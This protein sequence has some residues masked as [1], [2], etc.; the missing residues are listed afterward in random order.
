[1]PGYCDELDLAAQ[2]WLKSFKGMETRKRDVEHAEDEFGHSISRIERTSPLEKNDRFPKYWDSLKSPNLQLN[3]ATEKISPRRRSIELHLAAIVAVILQASLLVIA[4]VVPYRAH[5]YETQPWGLPCYIGG[6]VLLFIGMLACSVAIERST[7][8]FKW[9]PSSGISNKTQYSSEVRHQSMD[10]FWVQRKQ[11]VS[12]QDFDS[13]VIS[14]RNKQ[15]ISTSSRREDVLSGKNN[16]ENEDCRRIKIDQI[17]DN[18]SKNV[19]QANKPARS[20]EDRG[21]ESDFLAVTAIFAGGAGFTIQ[22]IGL[23][24]LPWPC[25]V[26]QLCATIAMAIIR[27]LVRRRLGD[28]PSYC[29]A[30]SRYELDLLATQLV[31]S[32]RTRPPNQPL[33]PSQKD[34]T[35]RVETAKHRL[36]STY[37][38][39][40]GNCLNP[41]ASSFNHE[42]SASSQSDQS[43]EA[44]Q[45]MLVRKRLGDLVRW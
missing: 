5:G 27:A 36:Q 28:D 21:L 37:W 20:A 10:L 32:S 24:G 2:N 42:Y 16:K 9:R 1:M 13:Y 6:S 23:R 18:A 8:E 31:D 33:R 30:P 40:I 15:F 22:F 45:I 26:A 12:D 43:N 17:D 14:S 11:R 19:P 25:A 39:R 34:W 44:Q 3:I 41:S 35:W 7:K 29:H 4:G 38:F